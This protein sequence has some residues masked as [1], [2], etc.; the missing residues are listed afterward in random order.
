MQQFSD[1]PREFGVFLP[2]ANGGW[3]I[4][5]N[6]P[7]LDGLYATNREAAMIAD[8]IGLDFIMSMSKWRGFGGETDHWR[9]SM[10][11]LTMM[12]GLAECTKNVKIWATMHTLIHNPAVVAKSITTL[13]YISNGRAGLNIVAGAYREEFAQ[14]GKWDDAMSHADRY[15][16]AEEWI[17]IVKRLWA[18]PGVTFD[19]KYFKMDDCQSDP[20]PLQR[21]RPT[22]IAAGQSDRGFDFATTHADASFISG[23][24]NEERRGHSRRAREVASRKGG[25][26]KVYAMCIVIH[27]E[28]DAKAEAKADYFDEG[29]D[30]GAIMA[31]LKSWGIPEVRAKTMAGQAKATHNY[32]VIGSPETC[33]EKIEEYMVDG[34]LD[35][36]MLIFPDYK[37]GLEMIGSEV[38]PKLRRTFA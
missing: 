20:K 13:D 8:R 22:L 28:T 23:A 26:I 35:G 15:D 18:E 38:L 4:S 33:R 32:P 36:V 17:T 11:S 30:L 5:K 19:G 25:K 9:N 24:T 29:R 6:A 7:R 16:L 3:V 37:E 12:A 31:Q 34:E 21:P 1:T 2:I 14:M 10:D 27:D